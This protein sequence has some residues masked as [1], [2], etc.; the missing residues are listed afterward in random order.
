MTKHMIAAFAALT[1]ISA[2]QAAV[3]LGGPPA[4]SAFYIWEG[5]VTVTN[6]SFASTTTTINPGAWSYDNTDTAAAQGWGHTSSWFL[7]DIQQA[8][9]FTLSM[10]A[11]TANPAQQAAARPGFVLFAGSANDDN[12][13][14]VH[15]YSNDGTDMALNDIWDSGTKLT[16]VTHGVNNAGNS[17]SQG[18]LLNPGLY[19]MIL[20]N[21]A[22]AS[23][24]PGTP[25]YSVTFAV[26]EPS[27][28]LLSVLG[29]LL[30]FKRRRR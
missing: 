9:Y 28:A 18:V 16:Y 25:Q 3:T 2:T 29:G 22:S 20:G 26:P 6:S 30:V 10:T 14:N 27:A 21:S 11:T 1:T 8:A 23:L 19:T 4:G 7:I 15:Q 13:D 17:L 24:T 5:T 12:A